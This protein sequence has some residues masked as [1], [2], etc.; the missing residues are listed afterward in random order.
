MS[1]ADAMAA[2][3]A[4]TPLFAAPEIMRGEEYGASCDVYSFGVMLLELASSD[5]LLPFLRQRWRESQVKSGAESSNVQRTKQ[6]QNDVDERQAMAMMR[7]IWQGNFRPVVLGGPPVPNAPPSVS[8]LIVRCTLHDPAARPPFSEVL[9]VL[10][11]NCAQEA[12][13]LMYIRGAES[14]S[15]GV[16]GARGNSQEVISIDKTASS[17][18]TSSEVQA[19]IDGRTSTNKTSTSIKIAIGPDFEDVCDQRSSASQSNL[20]LQS[21]VYRASIN[22]LSR[23][24]SAAGAEGTKRA[25]SSEKES[26]M[27]IQVT[28]TECTDV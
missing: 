16:E 15:R 27:S 26:R 11:N 4:G 24:S 17:A 13:A 18:A 6:A 23:G 12:E 10:A 9:T 22:P 28:K 21:Q 25:R 19:H 20:L 14:A 1:S 3:V 8:T 7:S 2:T 5:G